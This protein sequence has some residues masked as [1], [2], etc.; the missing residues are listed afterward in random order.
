MV[1][2]K[3]DYGNG[4]VY[5][6]SLINRDKDDYSNFFGYELD[7][8]YKDPGEYKITLS[9]TDDDNGTN[10]TSFKVTVEKEGFY[11]SLTSYERTYV[12]GTGSVIVI[13]IVIISYL[14]WRWRKGDRT[15]G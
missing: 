12:F 1:S 14:F 8:M 3:L 4:L 10:S 2:F 5:E 9:V 6:N 7:Y 13:V 11:E 15:G